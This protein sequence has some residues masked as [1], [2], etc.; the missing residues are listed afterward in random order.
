VVRARFLSLIGVVFLAAACGGSAPAE[1]ESPAAAGGPT[2]PVSATAR[3][4][5]TTYEFDMATSCRPDPTVA[6]GIS[7]RF[8][9]GADWISLTAA[10]DIV[11]VRMLLAGDEWVDQGSPTAP[12]ATGNTVTWSGTMTSTGISEDVELIFNC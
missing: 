3:V 9:K 1:T 5:A 8:E 10:G 7:L 4:G 2:G 6:P 11:L 12:E